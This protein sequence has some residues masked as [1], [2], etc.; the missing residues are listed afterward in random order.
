MD[1]ADDSGPVPGRG[2]GGTVLDGDALDD[3]LQRLIVLAT[4]AVDA[5]DAV[6]ITLTDG[7]GYRTSNTTSSDALAIDEAQ[8]AGGD[9]PCLKAVRSSHQLQATIGPATAHWPLFTER[10]TELGVT[11]VLSTPLITPPRTALGA[12]N[13]Y[14][15]RDEEFVD[16]ARATAE[17]IG[18]LAAVVMGSALD[19]RDCKQLNVQLR[20]AVASR[21][22]IGEAKGIL[23]E[24][25][26]CT[27]QEAFDMLR[28]ASQRENR[29]LRDLAT[30]LV[31]RVEARRTRAPG[32]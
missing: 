30:E 9:G 16:A 24:R 15:H 11:A 13:V 2:A 14:S 12:L 21:E 22:I 25:Q 7:D 17:I 8:Y 23:M 27:R 31:D 1:K 29:K 4:R 32:P 26:S 20:D 6:S 19:L 18:A 5:A 28:R 10:A 3:A